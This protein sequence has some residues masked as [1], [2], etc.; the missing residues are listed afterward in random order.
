MW[1]KGNLLIP[2]ENGEKICHYQIKHFAEPSEDYG[3][4]GSRISKAEIRIDGK[5]TL[6][7]DRGWSVEPEDE[8]TQLALLVLMKQYN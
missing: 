4:E 1:S 5:T 6:L 8:A 3:L 7:Y 2:T